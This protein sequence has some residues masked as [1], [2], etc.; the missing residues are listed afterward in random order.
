[1][2]CL[3]V[4]KGVVMKGYEFIER[5]KS[6][7][8]DKLEYH[9]DKDAEV[10]YR[11]KVEMICKEHNITFQQDVGNH[12]A[13]KLGCPVCTR[14]KRSKSRR[15]T[16][17]Q[18]IDKVR[19]AGFAED[20]WDLSEAEYLNNSTLVKIR[21]KKHNH[22][23][24]QLPATIFRGQSGCVKCVEEKYGVKRERSLKDA[25]KEASEK[26]EDL[27]D[28]S[29]I[30]SYEGYD[31]ELEVICK[32]HG[33]T[34]KTKWMYLFRGKT[35]CPACKPS[36]IS[37][38]QIDKVTLEDYIKSIPE[39][40]RSNLGNF[41]LSKASYIGSK[42]PVPV[43]CI[44]H[45]VWFEQTLYS[46]YKGHNNCPQCLKDNLSLGKEEFV[47]RSE[48]T[49]G[50]GRYDY[51]GVNYVNYTT[52]V[53]IRCV[54]HDHI[55]YQAPESHSLGFQGCRRCDMV[56][57]SKAEHELIDFLG[58][59]GIIF[60]HGDRTLIKP[61]EVDILI[62]SHKLAIE[63]NGTYY[64]SDKMKSKS[65]HKE[66]QELINQQ[67]YELFTIWEYDWRNPIKQKVIKRMLKNRLGK[68]CDKKVNA[69][70]CSIVTVDS[71]TAHSFFEMNH[72]QGKSGGGYSF[73]WGLE[74]NG[75]LVAVMSFKK[76]AHS[77][78]E[79]VRYTTSENVRGGASKLF[80]YALNN[81]PDGD[82]VSFSNTEMFTGGLYEKLGFL[83]DKELQPDYKVYHAKTDIHHKSKWRRS[84]IPMRLKEIGKSDLNFIPETDKR[85]EW[86]IQDEVKAFRLWDCGKIRWVY[87][88]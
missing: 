88:R 39:D 58:N 38:G 18:F 21:C 33:T 76:R 50:K 17:D 65:Y 72:I 9:L 59:L 82:I 42:T 19:K 28:F 64:H 6:M 34:H 79:L 47:K 20:L 62:D 35:P 61:L 4:E 1:M 14:A 15:L 43:R 37:K 80:K 77:F 67:G 74:N 10:F 60:K 3:K 5:S 46:I 31:Q 11:H 52:H 81:L 53:E 22:T 29:L 66:K 75:E 44:K 63:Y 70:S 36:R 54:E 68:G 78:W 16:Q 26:L 85:T 12:F 45:D 86:Q 13:G 8:G 2:Q 49:W 51:S 32:V 7:H 30:T 56:G 48:V 57:E 55:F 84:V 40:N 87:N 73:S 69:R 83:K 25:L 27:L 41:D 24:T 23:F 71:D